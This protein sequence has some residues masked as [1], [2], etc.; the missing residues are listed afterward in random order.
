M[1]LPSPVI[2][3]QSARR[4]LAYCV[5][6]PLSVDWR[7]KLKANRKATSKSVPS[8]VSLD[9]ASPSP[10]TASAQADVTA[11][12]SVAADGKPNLE[13]LSKSLPAGWRAMWDKNSGDIYYGN[14]KTRVRVGGKEQEQPPFMH[15]FVGMIFYH[16]QL[17]LL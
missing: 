8:T 3:Q 7:E 17:L 4:Q 9:S 10:A 16:M 12:V 5:L 14:L 13:L 11:D 1:L 2:D 15:N 6:Q